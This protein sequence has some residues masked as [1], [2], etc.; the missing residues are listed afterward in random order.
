MRR[1]NGCD[2]GTGMAHSYFYGYLKLVLSPRIDGD[3]PGRCI[4]FKLTSNNKF[5][6]IFFASGTY[7]LCP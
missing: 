5:F 2:Y 7:F 3:K 1:M 6:K 4:I